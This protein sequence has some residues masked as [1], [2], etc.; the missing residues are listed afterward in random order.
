MTD[1]TTV[2]THDVRDVRLGA[3]TNNVFCRT[4]IETLFSLFKIARR[5][6]KLLSVALSSL[7]VLVVIDLA[8][9]FFLFGHNEG[10][11]GRGATCEKYERLRSLIKPLMNQ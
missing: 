11:I 5:C 8:L 2:P 3:I 9:F 1:L 6:F 4:T 10:I 7:L